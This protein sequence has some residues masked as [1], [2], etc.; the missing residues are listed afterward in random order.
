VPDDYSSRARQGALWTSIHTVVSLPLS[1]LANIIV[2][3]ELGL[4]QFGLLAVLSLSL[5]LAGTLTDFG[6][7]GAVL[8]WATAAY[9]KGDLELATVLLQ[10]RVGFGLLFQA[11]TMVLVVLLVGE[12]EGTVIVVALVVAILFSTQLQGVSLNVAVENRTALAA[13]VAIV[14]NVALQLVVVTTALRTHNGIDTWAARVLADAIF[15]ASTL[16][17]V[18]RSRRWRLLMPRLPRGL[19]DRFWRY[20]V[21]L[22]GSSVVAAL[23]GSRTETFVLDIFGRSQDV[24]LFA[25]AYGIAAHLTAPVDASL[26]PTSFSIFTMLTAAPARVRTAVLRVVRYSAW[27]CGG[28]IAVAVPP[29]VAILPL[30]YGKNYDGV[31][32]VFVALAIASGFLTVYAP[33]AALLMGRRDG[34]LLWRLGLL[35]LGLDAILTFSLVPVFGLWGA[36]IGSTMSSISGVPFVLTKEAKRG[37]PSP[38]EFINSSRTFWIA[39]PIATLAIGCEAFVRNPI[40][41]SVTGFI[42]GLLLYGFVLKAT[43]GALVASELEDVLSVLPPTTR[44]LVGKCLR[45]MGWAG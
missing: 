36:V 32:P 11:S 27:S 42:V 13:R 8:Q 6:V 4:S 26:A 23:A 15:S 20:A 14:R 7:P 25:L 45:V 41:A 12:H 33:I 22:W 17:V 37:G 5:Q 39:L 16:L 29:L 44:K 40:G 18:D 34:G 43:R 9:A 19:P 31:T 3:R 28:I 35:G 30:I 1:F 38:R 21:P 10:K 2:A 24:G